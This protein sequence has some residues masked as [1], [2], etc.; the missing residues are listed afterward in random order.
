MKLATIA[1]GF[2]FASCSDGS[3]SVVPTPA[4]PVPVASIAGAWSGTWVSFQGPGGTVFVTL[5]QTGEAIAAS[6]LRLTGAQCSINREASGTFDGFAL[7]L[8]GVTN[9][10]LGEILF[11]GLVDASGNSLSG[12]YGITSGPCVGDFGEWAM[13]LQPNQP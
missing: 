1:L 4:P 5:S 12:S 6:G 7:E 13:T 9:G 3:S 8:T 2:L 10:S 11:S